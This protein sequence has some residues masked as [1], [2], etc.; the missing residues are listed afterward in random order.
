[1]FG[2]PVVCYLFLGGV[3][4]G[5]CLVASGLSLVAPRQVLRHS[6]CCEFRNL[7]GL[8]FAFAAAALVLG[9][10][11]LIVDGV[12]VEELEHL[13]FPSRP[14]LLS[15]GSWV[16]SAG[17]VLSAALSLWW[18]S[19]G[20]GALGTHGG[21]A[22]HTPRSTAF[23]R[24]LFACGVV[25]GFAIVVYTGVFLASM[26][27]VAL[28]NTWWL[29]ALFTASALSC[30]AA[31]VIA[32]ARVSG[33]DRMVP[34]VMAMLV[35]ADMLIVAFEAL[36]A[37]GFM[38]AAFADSS[39]S[40]AAL[41]AQGSARD[42]IEGEFSWLWWLCFVGGGI[43]VAFLLDFAGLHDRKQ[44]S[45]FG[46]G[47]RAAGAADAARHAIPLAGCVLA[48]AFALRFCVVAAAAHP[49]MTLL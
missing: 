43:A 17:I 12:R 45:V 16:I 8:S 5:V 27:A 14:T 7:L 44:A 21:P 19:G 28:W 22:A 9:A 25:V 3:G 26:S 20:F 46:K 6:A 49:A 23:L 38:M 34:S 2:F 32:I 18:R 10:L 31:A 48:G 4:G 1:M 41:A 47:L 15:A 40:S 33:S 11:C 29:P 13:F 36:C 35:R 30:G 37:A 39:G 24:A 42:L